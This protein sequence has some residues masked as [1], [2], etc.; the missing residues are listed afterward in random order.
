MTPP[1]SERSRRALK[2]VKEM[3]P[4]TTLPGN[5]WSPLPIDH[6]PTTDGVENISPLRLLDKKQVIE[7]VGVSFPTI[8]KWMRAGTFPRARVV[9]DLKSVWYEHEIEA[10]IAALPMRRLKDDVS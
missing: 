7:R 3:T 6:P 5:V 2:S 9:G 10:W 1:K 4:T 8:W